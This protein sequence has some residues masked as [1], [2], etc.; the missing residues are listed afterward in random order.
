MYLQVDVD[1]RVLKTQYD[2][3]KQTLQDDLNTKA[4]TTEVQ[5]LR[6]SFFYKTR[7]QALK[8]QMFMLKPSDFGILPSTFAILYKVYVGY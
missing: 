7:I 6:V 8:G 2:N 4:S 5:S 1:K 3:M